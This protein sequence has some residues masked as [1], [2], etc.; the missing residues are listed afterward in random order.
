MTP[1]EWTAGVVGWAA[2]GQHQLSQHSELALTV[3]S[4]FFVRQRS[5]V[6]QCGEQ[7][8]RS[9]QQSSSVISLTAH[10]AWTSS[11]TSLQD[12]QHCY[13]VKIDSVDL[14]S[15][16][17]DLRSDQK[18]RP[19]F[20]HSGGHVTYSHTVANRWNQVAG[21]PL[22]CSVCIHGYKHANPQSHRTL[23]QQL[24]SKQGEVRS[25][26]PHHQQNWHS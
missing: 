18:L 14:Y 2:N 25:L 17:S 16:T 19:P 24:R 9:T 11:S 5:A 8:S 23:Q 7:H 12:F 13:W 22:H 21:Q 1:T 4:V 26:S 15:I 10:N 20:E 6:S 3:V